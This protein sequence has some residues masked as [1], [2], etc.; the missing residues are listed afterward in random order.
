[1]VVLFDAQI[2]PALLIFHLFF[3]GD[4]RAPPPESIDKVR[5]ILL[6]EPV[7]DPQGVFI[8]GGVEIK[9]APKEVVDRVGDEELVGCGCV[10]AHIEKDAADPIRCF[11]QGLVNGA[12]LIRMFESH[13]KGIVPEFVKAVARLLRVL[14]A[15]LFVTDIDPGAEAGKID[16]D[17]IWVFRF[18]FEK[19][20]IAYYFCINGIFEGIRIAGLIKDL[21]LM[22]R[23][24]YFEITFLFGCIDTV[25]GKDQG[26]YGERSCDPS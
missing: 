19:A 1:M 23:K 21:V 3:P 25:A 5:H 13:F 2:Y 10:A 6:E 4:A 18:C 24:I 26:C 22:R 14:G 11:Y 15:D 12:G 17:P 7:D 9:G 16:I 8:R 20:R